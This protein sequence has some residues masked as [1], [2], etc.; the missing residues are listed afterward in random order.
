MIIQTQTLTTSLSEI[1][2]K[3]LSSLHLN[4]TIQELLLYSI[5][6][7]ILNPGEELAK[8]FRDFPLLPGV[9]IV[10]QGKF[11]NMISRVHFLEIMSHP[12]S[13][14]LFMKR[15]IKILLE[16]FRVQS[17]IFSGDMTIRD[18]TKKSLQRPTEVLYEPIIVDLS[19]QK[20]AVADIH[21]LL[22]AH[23][24]IHE[25]TTK[26]L[27][28]AY[29]ELEILTNLDGLT[30]IY[31]RRY[32]NICYEQEWQRMTRKKEY[33]S[34]IMCDIDYF[35]QYNDYYGH[36]A[37]D[38]CI[39]KIAQTIKNS[40]KRSSDFVAR[41][42]GEEFVVVLPDTSTKG[43]IKIAE[44][45]KDNVKKI[46]I[47]HKKSSISEYISIS[48]GVATIIPKV[49]IPSHILISMADQALYTAKNKGRNRIEISQKNL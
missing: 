4:S 44:D 13:L 25:L 1:N 2:Q 41:Y 18:A 6:I 33:L 31:N 19:N 42:G 15:P 12:Y 3:I 5:E 9:L 46:Q 48:L 23:S 16:A 38:E 32:F 47:P 40:I 43:A 36:L 45:I 11:M 7:D 30:N 37:G 27:K 34:I 21:Q 8:T 28:Q 35:K 20:Y 17:F 22:M 24:E 49:D 14:E 39:Y 26:K 29:N 10:K